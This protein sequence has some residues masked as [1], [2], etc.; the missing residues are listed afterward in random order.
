MPNFLVGRSITHLCACF[1]PAIDLAIE[2][3]LTMR[4][5]RK[6]PCVSGL[7]L[8]T[9]SHSSK[10]MSPAAHCEGLPFGI[11]CG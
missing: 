5:A 10:S 4:R 3:K 2:V 1:D 8:T 11:C 6:R 7:R 9:P